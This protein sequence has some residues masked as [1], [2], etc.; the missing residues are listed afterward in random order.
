MMRRFLEN[1]EIN[2][3]EAYL[4]LSLTFIHT[5]LA[6]NLGLSP[7]E[8]HYALYARFI[9][10]SYYDHPPM[11]GWM[12]YIFYTLSEK[13]I[14]LRVIPI[15]SWMTSLLL[16]LHLNQKVKIKLFDASKLK[17][18]P[19][20]IRVSILLFAF[21]PLLHLLSIALVPDTLLIPLVLLI[22]SVT[23]DLIQIEDIDRS[24]WRNWLQ[25][26][27]LL[28]LAGL[29]KYTAVLFALSA[30]V[31]I[32]YKY[33]PKVLLTYKIW[34]AIAIALI[35]ISPVLIWNL[36]HDWISFRYQLNHAAGSND[37]ILRKC[38]LFA[39]VVYLAYGPLLFNGIF[40]KATAIHEEKQNEIKHFF[41]VFS[42]P[43]L[44]LL[45]VLSG[46]GST[47][48]HWAA[49]AVVALIPFVAFKL[50]NI[51]HETSRT[52]KYTLILQIVS[53][54]VL[55]V[56][57]TTAGLGSE[58]NLEKISNYKNT[59]I[60]S[61]NN[62]I[63]DLYGWESAGQRSRE[64]TKKYTL[65]KIAVSNWTLAS[66]IAW[67]AR[68]LSVNVIDNHHDQF[69]IWFG[70]LKK[71]DSILWVDWSMMPFEA[72]IGKNKFESCELIDQLPIIHLG[73]QIS[74]FNFS[75]C[76]NWLGEEHQLETNP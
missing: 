27:V 41:L 39:L 14:S 59:D 8:A 17:A 47:L 73:R 4:I 11:V 5:L 65:E 58:R 21:S 57:L 52:F 15:V 32:L 26:G 6:Y 60:R 68:P 28:G 42:I 51:N 38:V 46:R 56:F 53:T 62:P 35:F 69:D 70:S 37:W 72:P 67:Y 43:S 55:M 36:Q 16:V 50:E 63:A 54:A 33:G 30:A 49:P 12:Q 1:L 18:T 23:W 61:Q 75:I 40:K 34:V 20:N 48:P 9:D 10:W 3:Y 44:I 29:T 45:L 7:D 24:S 64:I 76:K 66:R 13:E 25:L 2:R 31:L 74:H 71:N 19:V 22:M